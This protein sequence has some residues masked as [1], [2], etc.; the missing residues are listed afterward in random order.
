MVCTDL[1]NVVMYDSVVGSVVTLS[2]VVKSSSVVLVDGS[3][4]KAL[5]VVCVLV[6][7]NSSVVVDRTVDVG[8]IV[9]VKSEGNMHF[10]SKSHHSCISRLML[11]ILE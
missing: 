3:C 10:Y 7:L 8:S 11:C 1:S 4:A 6:L 5:Y 9:V 2:V